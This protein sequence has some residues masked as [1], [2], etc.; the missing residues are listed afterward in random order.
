LSPVGQWLR[1]L[2]FLL[3]TPCMSLTTMM[4]ESTFMAITSTGGYIG[5]IYWQNSG[6]HP[7]FEH[8][9][10]VQFISDGTLRWGP[11]CWAGSISAIRQII[12]WRFYDH[13]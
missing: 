12:N 6:V 9:G 2:L 5:R 10:S 3:T 7:D 11:S 4:T 8:W 13:D 1:L